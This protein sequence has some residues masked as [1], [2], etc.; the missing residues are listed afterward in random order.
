MIPTRAQFHTDIPLT[1]HSLAYMQ[2]DANFGAFRVFKP[3]PVGRRSD[4]YHVY[5]RG[6]F[7]RLVADIRSPSSEVTTGGYKLSLQEFY[8]ERYGIGSDIDV[9]EEEDADEVLDPEEDRTEWV[10]RQLLMLAESKFLTAAFTAGNPGDTWTY[11]V[12]GVASGET[13]ASSFDA[14]S[15]ANNDVLQWNDADSDPIGDVRRGRM[16]I[17]GNSGLSRTDFVLA[18]QVEVVETLKE[19]PSIIDR[20]EGAAGPGNPAVV[21]DQALATILGVR[22]V[23]TL[24]SVINSAD[25]G[26]TDSHAFAAAK[27]ALLIWDSP[28]P[29]RGRMTPA[30]GSGFVWNGLAGLNERGTRI[31]RLEIEERTTVRIEGESYFDFKVQAPDLGYFFG[32]I[33]A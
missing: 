15:A 26:Q 31:R 12:D 18:A 27:N 33:V 7:N 23:V 16:S 14:T 30:V 24:A 20:I 10:T 19:H 4:K 28:G 13:A 1:D 3:V 2:D 11:D 25:E 32:G 21:S 9:V 29:R 5:D 22:E 17:L 6:D 8:C